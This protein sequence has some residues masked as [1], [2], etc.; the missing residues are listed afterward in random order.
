MDEVNEVNEVNEV[1]LNC[2][3]M[4][5]GLPPV[6]RSLTRAERFRRVAILCRHYLRNLAFYRAGWQH[7]KI[8][9]DSQFWIV[10]NG[11]FID[12]AVLEWCKLFGDPGGKH[13]W[14]KVIV[15]RPSF[16][17]GLL[18][19][20]GITKKEFRAYVET[21]LRYRNKFVAHLDEE[22]IAHIP[23]MGVARKAVAYLYNYIIRQVEAKAYLPD[24]NL[25]AC[26]FYAVMF[27][28][29]VS[30]YRRRNSAG[31]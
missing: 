7:G 21:V 17:V 9:I 27:R 16:F 28:Q 12:I 30:E 31:A 24:V 3:G 10:A 20:I 15:D 6:A 13:H 19:H 23:R 18:K 11:N 26:Q 2:T 4:T 8:R 29:A 22:R 25:S 5:Y 1:S 14:K